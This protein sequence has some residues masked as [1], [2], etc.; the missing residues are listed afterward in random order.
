MA[1]VTRDNRI[2]FF[3]EAV[4]YPKNLH[5]PEVKCKSLTAAN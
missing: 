2:D 5:L 1:G 3:V 4:V